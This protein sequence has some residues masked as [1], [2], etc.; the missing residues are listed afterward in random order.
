MNFLA[1]QQGT[2]CLYLRVLGLGFREQLLILKKHSGAGQEDV[3]FWYAH[4]R[5]TRG[6]VA[7]AVCLPACMFALCVSKYVCKYVCTC[8]SK[9]I[10]IKKSLSTSTSL[11][12]SISLSI[13]LSISTSK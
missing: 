11:S 9:Y 10:C 2:G 8:A 5:A 3:F 13:S 1:P 6:Q 4:A 7:R 12:I